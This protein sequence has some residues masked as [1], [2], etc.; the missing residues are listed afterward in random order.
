MSNQENNTISSDQHGG[1]LD[2]C[3]D[4]TVSWPNGHELKVF[5]MNPSEYSQELITIVKLAAKTWET[6]ANI[7]IIFVNDQES[8]DIRISLQSTQGDG[9]RGWSVLGRHCESRRYDEPTMSVSVGRLAHRKAIRSVA[10]HEWGHSL[11]IIH[12]HS[13]PACQIVWDRDVVISHCGGNLHKANTNYFFR[14]EEN[15]T[16]YSPFDPES[17]MIYNIKQIF[18]KNYIETR[19]GEDLSDTDKQWAGIFYPFP[20]TIQ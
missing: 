19:R 10:L 15:K 8:S 16:R 1:C 6:Y 9:V 13:S 2:L 17:I 7:K 18:M 4:S 5:F 20:G 3:I 11:G 14:A 12:E